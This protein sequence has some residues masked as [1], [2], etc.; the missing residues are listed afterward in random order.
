MA[1]ARGNE[2]GRVERAIRFVRDAFFV[3]RTFHDV[4]DLNAQALTWCL[5]LAADRPCP[6]DPA[7]SVRESLTQEQPLLL[8]N[9]SNHAVL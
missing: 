5:G 9:R 3:T 2:K 4:N 6:E 1:V 8:R 7:R